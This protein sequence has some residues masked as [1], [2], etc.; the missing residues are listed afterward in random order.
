MNIIFCSDDR[1]RDIKNIKKAE[2][3]GKSKKVIKKVKISFREK[4]NKYLDTTSRASGKAR[5]N[6]IK[7]VCSG[8]NVH[9]QEIFLNS[10]SEICEFFGI[11]FNSIT[12]TLFQECGCNIKEKKKNNTH[13]C[14]KRKPT[15]NITSKTRE[16]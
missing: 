15:K 10:T 6:E 14:E 2:G 8:G 4:N 3:T 12:S 1:E 5:N 13:E 11:T 9:R 16:K 7:F